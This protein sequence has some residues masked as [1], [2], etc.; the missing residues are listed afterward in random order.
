MNINFIYLKLAINLLQRLHEQSSQFHS[1]IFA[2]KIH[3][4][5]ES[6]IAFGTFCH[7]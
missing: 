3:G 4:N 5:E 6:F 1:F 2:L 7:N